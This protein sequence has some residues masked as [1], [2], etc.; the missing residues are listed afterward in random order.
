MSSAQVDPDHYRIALVILFSF[1]G[2]Q[3][4]IFLSKAKM[5]YRA[6]IPVTGRGRNTCYLLHD[7][8][9]E[10]KSRYFIYIS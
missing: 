9:S 5:K 3:G 1:W 4:T 8:S 7:E 2:I 10:S 6:T